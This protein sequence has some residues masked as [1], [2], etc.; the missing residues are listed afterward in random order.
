MS[1]ANKQP[2][3]D[4]KKKWLIGA[5]CLIVVLLSLFSIV[6]Q[7]PARSKTGT[8]A[9][10]YPGAGGA[11]GGRQMPG[12]RGQISAV[13]ARAIT[14]QP[15][16]GAPKTF[17]ITPATKITVDQ[18]TVAATDLKAGQ[19]ARVVSADD[20][21]ATEIRVRTRPF[22]GRGGRRGGSPGSPPAMAPAPQ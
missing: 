6:R 13:T 9:G 7:L 12:T 14:L 20:K 3:E 19:R 21:T 8:T 1:I 16:N 2:A 18:A 10:G 17:A 11:P 15:R 4:N 5:V 22:G